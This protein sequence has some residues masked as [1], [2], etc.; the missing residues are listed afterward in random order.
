MSFLHSSFVQ[1]CKLFKERL[2]AH[3]KAENPLSVLLTIVQLSTTAISSEEI[4]QLVSMMTKKFAAALPTLSRDRRLFIR[5]SILMRNVL[6]FAAHVN[7]ESAENMR[8]EG[9]KSLY[10]VACKIV[11]GFIIHPCPK[12]KTA[13]EG[14]K[15][16][17]DDGFDLDDAHYVDASSTLSNSFEDRRERRKHTHSDDLSDTSSEDEDE[18]ER[19]S[20]TFTQSLK[21]RRKNSDR[22][23][24]RK[25]KNNEAGK[26]GETS[27]EYPDSA[28]ALIM[29]SILSILSPTRKTLK[30]V[31]ER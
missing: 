21:K 26:N 22:R 9:C 3:Q 20:M 14:Q 31:A 25:H 30:L 2:R 19:L 10:D 18:G 1:L 24:D 29:V 17:L 16:E 13:E 11:K 23:T 8:V 27:F 6:S 15:D 28:G 12:T 5:S 4:S 7:I